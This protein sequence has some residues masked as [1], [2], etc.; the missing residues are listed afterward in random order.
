MPYQIT[1][2]IVQKPQKVVIY[3]PEGVGKSSLAACFP[4]PLFIDTEGG[5]GHL[6]VRRLPEPTSW[7]M[8][9]DEVKWVRDYPEECGGTLV[10]D[11]AD[12]AE[13][14]CVEHVCSKNQWDGI[15]TPG[16]GKG[17]NTAVEEFCRLLNLLSELPER[18]L[19][20]VV[21]AHA[22]I[23]KFEQPDELGAYDRW[24]LKLIDG[25]KASSAAALK[26]WADA[27]LFANFKTVVTEDKNGKK[28]AQGGKNHVLYCTHAATWDAKNRW[29]LPDEIPM[30]WSLIAPNIPVPSIKGSS[31][32]ALV[33][34]EDIEAAREMPVPFDDPVDEGTGQEVTAPRDG[35]GPAEPEYMA[36]LRDLME[37]DGVTDEVIQQVM[38]RKGYLPEGMPLSSYPEDIARWVVSVWPQIIQYIKAGMPA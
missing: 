27:V 36:P 14:L 12:W 10:V 11:T 2:G 7:T 30:D 23:S 17:Y 21:T 25:K 16:Y 22:V 31:A 28:K 33:T 15:E 9:M 4:S 38:S 37:K 5:S 34:P 29:G 1:S 6:D 13:R 8:L 20:V 35:D 19:N 24:G 18:G 32:A 3:G 26:E